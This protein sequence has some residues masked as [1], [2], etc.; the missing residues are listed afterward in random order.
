MLETRRKQSNYPYEV[1]HHMHWVWMVVWN[2]N[3]KEFLRKIRFE[4]AI[5]VEDSANSQKM[6]LK[7]WSVWSAKWVGILRKSTV[8][9]GNE[10]EGQRKFAENWLK[11]VVSM[12]C[13]MGRNSLGNRRFE[14]VM[15]AKDSASSQ[16]MDLKWWS[17][18]SAKWVGI[19]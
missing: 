12:E 17:V 6:N 2:A 10:R 19:P 11:V 16:K 8:W 3:C 4:V 13:K 15:S 14:A 1:A 18:W 9:G 7:W 5:D